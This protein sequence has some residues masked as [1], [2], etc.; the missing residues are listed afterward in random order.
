LKHGLK[1]PAQFAHRGAPWGDGLAVKEDFAEGGLDQPE[2]HAGHR[3]FAGAGFADEAEGFAALN[4]ERNIID[5]D[6]FV[7]A[8]GEVS[9]FEQEHQAHANPPFGN[10]AREGGDSAI[11]RV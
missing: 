8:L 2:H 6:G 11:P 4:E 3:A 5:H 10:G 1:A 7:V 9:G